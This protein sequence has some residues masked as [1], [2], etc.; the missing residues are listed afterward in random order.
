MWMAVRPPRLPAHEVSF[1][2]AIGRPRWSITCL[3]RPSAPDA[4][5]V[6][7]GKPLRSMVSEALPSRPT[8]FIP[9]RNK[10]AQRRLSGI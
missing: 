4:V 7:R 10:K 5:R 2:G 9:R 1:A 3:N 6:P 8:T